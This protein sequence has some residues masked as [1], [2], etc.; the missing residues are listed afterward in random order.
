M[1][2]SLSP[3]KQ[4]EDIEVLSAL[5][6]EIWHEHYSSI[7]SPAQIEY[8]LK[9]FQSPSAIL[10]QIEAQSYRYFFLMLNE[11]PVGYLAWRPEEYGAFIS[12]I[13]IQKRAR[14]NGL[15]RLAISSVEETLGKGILSL[16]V[17]RY[18]EHSI[19]AYQHLGFTITKEQQADI[20]EGYIMDDYIM[21]K[22]FSL[23][24]I[25]GENG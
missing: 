15:A 16:T 1:N 3:I 19:A 6:E 18:N 20:G 7:L 14:G 24:A 10:S 9:K 5:A 2:C 13:Y 11:C 8:M 21:E 12:K 17:N 23:S 4:A 25:C 22:A